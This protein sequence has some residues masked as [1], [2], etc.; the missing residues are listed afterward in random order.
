MKLRHG[1]LR[2]FGAN[3]PYSTGFTSLVNGTVMSFLASIGMM[4]IGESIKLIRIATVGLVLVV[5]ALAQDRMILGSRQFEFDKSGAGAVLCSWSIYLSIRTHSQ[6]CGL[7][8]EPVD[9]AI[10]QAITAI[11]EFIIANSSLHPTREMLEEFKQRAANQELNFL[12]QRGLQNAC[13]PGSDVQHFRR[14]TPE[15]IQT[16]VKSLLATPR[17]PVMNPCL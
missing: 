5:P 10:D 11:D 4:V 13:G 12:R 9:D 2:A 1:G 16:S 7:A 15:Q 3:P 17:E 6:A 14:S 8:R